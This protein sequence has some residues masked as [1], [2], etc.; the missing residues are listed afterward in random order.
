MYRVA[1]DRDVAAFDRR[2][3]SYERDRFA[4]WHRQVTERMAEVVLASGPAPVRTLDVGCGTGALLRVL[5][6]RLPGAVELVGVDAARG[7]VAAGWSLPDLDPRIQLIQAAAER[8]PFRDASFD[9]VVSTTSFDHWADQLRG[10]QECARMLRGDGRLVLA[11]LFGGW[12]AST[13]VP[14]RRSRARTVRRAS[15][16]LLAAGF[17]ELSWQRLYSLGP[18]PLVQAVI[19]AR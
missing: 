3:T 7:M 13:T 8:L 11:D 18:L 12:L 9:L 19:A 10:L 1:H 6:A 5:A 17:S 16:L 15:R 2:A 4:G 14:G